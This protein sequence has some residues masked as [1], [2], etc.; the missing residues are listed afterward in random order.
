MVSKPCTSCGLHKRPRDFY[1]LIPTR[2]MAHCKVCHRKAVAENREAKREHY[3]NYMRE[4]N[5]RPERKEKLAA[6]ANT[7]KGK[8]IK[9]T[10][11]RIVKGK[12]A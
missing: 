8:E 7:A 1:W 6:Y 3:L 11:Y 5:K 9:R 2:R 4:Y 12:A 10:W